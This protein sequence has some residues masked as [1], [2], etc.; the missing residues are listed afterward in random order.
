MFHWYR[1]Y[2]IQ[3]VGGG[4]VW[5]W[6][7][8]LIDIPTLDPRVVYQ[9]HFFKKKSFSSLGLRELYFNFLK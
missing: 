3:I 5:Q 7:F 8:K 1:I 4:R 6:H 9:R 2:K